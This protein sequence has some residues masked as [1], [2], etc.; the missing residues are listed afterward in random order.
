MSYNLV[1]GKGN[2]EDVDCVGT[3]MKKNKMRNENVVVRK[4]RTEAERSESG[5][6]DVKGAVLE[7]FSLQGS[8]CKFILKGVLFL[9]VFHYW[10]W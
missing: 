8:L 5:Q 6:N 4:E 1:S 10:Y 3:E 2:Y 9:K 7:T